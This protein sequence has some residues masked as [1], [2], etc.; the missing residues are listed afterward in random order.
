[1]W[2]EARAGGASATKC[3]VL[4]CTCGIAGKMETEL[5]FYLFVAIHLSE[6]AL[7]ARSPKH[8][9]VGWGSPEQALAQP[10]ITHQNT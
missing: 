3:K 1:N 9:V 5:L 8:A 7:V 10:I 4:A 6:G 2:T